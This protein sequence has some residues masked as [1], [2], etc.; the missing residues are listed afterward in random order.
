MTMVSRR[1]LASYGTARLL[2]GQPIKQVARELGAVLAIQKRS[3]ETDLLVS[4]IGSE[5]E[6]RGAAA[7]ASV[8][9]AGPLNDSLRR[10]IT[11]FIKQSAQVKEVNLDEKID[12]AVLAGIKVETS[13]RLWDKTAAKTLSAIR[14]L[15]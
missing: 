6:R 9:T 1:R 10:E 4:D 5:L 14:E 11:S 2:E 15:F 7:W 8:T 13:S 3:S 12:K